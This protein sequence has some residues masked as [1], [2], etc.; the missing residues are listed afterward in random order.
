VRSPT[1]PLCSPVRDVTPSGRGG[2]HAL[3]PPLRQVIWPEK[4]KAGHIDKY[5]GFSNPKEFIQV[6]HTVIEAVEGDDRIK[7]NYLPTTLSDAAR[8]W[9]INLPDGCIYIWN[10]LCTMFI[11][12][13]YGTYEHPST[14]ETLKTIKQKHDESL[15]GYV[16][17]FCIAKNTILYIQDIKIINAFR[18]GVSDIKT[19]EEITIK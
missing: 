10:Q 19:M 15:R 12:N 3:A 7:V 9:L 14:A 5:D 6:Y 8:S 11:G 1:P 13:F 16:K 17:H 4:F 2:F 18:D